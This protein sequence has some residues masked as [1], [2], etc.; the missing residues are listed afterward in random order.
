MNRRNL[1]MLLLG[2]AGFNCPIPRAQH[3]N[4]WL[5]SVL[6]LPA[7]PDRLEASRF[8]A[9]VRGMREEGYVEGGNLQN[10]VALCWRRCRPIAKARRRAD[11]PQP[12]HYR[13]RFDAGRSRR[14][15]GNEY[16]S[17]RHGRRL[18]V[19]R[20]LRNLRQQLVGMLLFLK[21][22]LKKT[23]SLKVPSCLAQAISVP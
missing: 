4:A 20:T 6:A 5:V 21:V 13:R 12:R 8:G 2:A 14:T 18:L 3:R 17:N 1:L 9:F 23:G 10:R 19:G 7:R 16:D 11:S 22:L 15:D